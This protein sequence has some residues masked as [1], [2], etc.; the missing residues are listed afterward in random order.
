MVDNQH[1]SQ[2]SGC[3]VRKWNTLRGV[4]Q[5]EFAMAG[6]TLPLFSKK[7]QPKPISV[8]STK[9]PYYEKSISA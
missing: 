1:V 3:S 5:D 7:P 8:V 2:R 6:V 4:K 9:T